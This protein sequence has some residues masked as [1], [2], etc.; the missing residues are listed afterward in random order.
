VLIK[1]KKSFL[2]PNLG[3]SLIEVIIASAIVSSLVLAISFVSTKGIT[4]SN[5]A[6]KEVQT[7]NLLSE[8]AEAVRLIRDNSWTNISSLQVGTNYYLNFDTNTN[9]WSLTQTPNTI[10][11]FTR[12][13]TVSNVYRDVNNDIASTGTLDSN[14]KL[15][16]ITTTFNTKDG[17]IT[18]QLQLYIFNI[19]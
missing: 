14:S 3:F 11:Y 9:L 2:K 19:F 4:L 1:M 5:R 15:F 18:K 6:L 16:T 8:G 12:T 17:V 10:D 7:T 13:I